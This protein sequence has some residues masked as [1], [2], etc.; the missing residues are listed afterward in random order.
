METMKSRSNRMLVF[1]LMILF[2]YA[3]CENDTIVEKE[4]EKV[5]AW[6]LVPLFSH[7]NKMQLNSYGD[8]SGLYTLNLS[9][10][11]NARRS[12]SS[13]RLDLVLNLLFLEPSLYEKFP[14][15]SRYFAVGAENTVRISTLEDPLSYGADAWLYMNQ[16]DTNFIEFDFPPYWW[17]N[18]I[19][20]NG[21]NSVLIPYLRN[22]SV[23]YHSAAMLVTFSISKNSVGEKLDTVSTTVLRFGMHDSPLSMYH[24]F[25]HYFYSGY[26]T[27]RIG[28]DGN[29][30]VCYPEG[31]YN[32]FSNGTDLFSMSYGALLR[33]KD[34]G[35]TWQPIG[36]VSRTVEVMSYTEA[37]GNIISF[38]DSRLYHVTLNDSV[39][40]IVELENDGLDGHMITSVSRY[41]DDIYVTT[42]SG[43]FSRPV[44]DFYTERQ[45]SALQKRSFLQ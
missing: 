35:V 34:H 21:K 26:K 19:A 20:A 12:A 24:Y 30:A 17:S 10:I 44:K 7:D 16:I 1:L 15:C 9:Y 37:D 22:D 13:G 14:V 6:N 33:S 39:N 40:T 42:R 27:Y 31:M 29:S 38:R 41:R 43:V 32:M 18:A 2:A 36:G 23:Y 5:H 28:N 8:S 4:V 3:G 11:T 25:D 45:G